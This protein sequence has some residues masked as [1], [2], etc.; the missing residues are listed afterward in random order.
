MAT[1]GGVEPPAVLMRDRHASTATPPLPRSADQA[2]DVAH[3]L[4]S[5]HSRSPLVCLGFHLGL[6]Q[7]LCHFVG[8]F[9]L[10]VRADYGTTRHDLRVCPA[11]RASISTITS[12]SVL[13]DATPTALMRRCI[14]AGIETSTLLILPSPR[15]RL[16]IVVTLSFLCYE[17]N[18]LNNTNSTHNHIMPDIGIDDSYFLQSNYFM[19]IHSKAN[20]ETL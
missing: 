11:A 2:L 6:T 7:S 16:S 20:V 19:Y 8:C 13:S 15:I 4:P 12:S 5:E 17:R 14:S 9:I 18:L 3:P 1:T 10:M